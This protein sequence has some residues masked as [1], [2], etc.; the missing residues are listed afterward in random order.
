MKSI[1]PKVIMVCTR[2][3]PEKSQ[4]GREKTLDFIFKSLSRRGAVSFYRL[5]SVFEDRSLNRLIRLIFAFV[6]GLLRGAS[7]PM[8]SLLFYDVSQYRR[9]VELVLLEKPQSVYFDGVRSGIMAIALRK[10]FPD[11]HMVCDFDDLMSRRMRMLAILKKPIALGYLERYV[12]LWLKKYFL[13][14]LMGRMIRAYEIRAL[15]NAEKAILA[16]VNSAVLVSSVD[17]QEIYKMGLSGVEVIPPY[18]QRLREFSGAD[19]V[20]RFIF[21]GSDALLQNKLTID[22]LISLWGRVNPA[23]ELHIYGKQTKSYLDVSGVVFHG[24]VNSLDDIYSPGSIL[25][26]P[27]FIGGGVKTKVLEAMSYGAIVL[28]TDVT[29]E[30]IDAPTEGLVVGYKDWEKVVCNP[31]DFSKSWNEAGER[32][33]LAVAKSHSEEYLSSRWCDVVWPC[34][35]KNQQNVQCGG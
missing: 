21:I 32:V 14:G 15:I 8:Q 16:V 10:R 34:S 29:F 25:I 2:D 27:S 3:I 5:T 17:A 23:L 1:F 12:P 11:L 13:D 20:R 30:G 22:F 26:A 7:L 9:L 18:I 6:N 4:N 31:A 28:G 33:V 35:Y 24:F 19:P